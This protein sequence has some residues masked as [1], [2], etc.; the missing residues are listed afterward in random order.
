MSVPAVHFFK[1]FVTTGLDGKVNKTVD[2]GVL[3][4]GFDEVVREVPGVGGDEFDV[5][6]LRKSFRDGLEELREESG[7]AETAK[8]GDKGGFNGGAIRKAV[9]LVPFNSP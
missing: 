5:G 8:V 6:E 7:D 1:N 4:D 2:L 9:N 3:R